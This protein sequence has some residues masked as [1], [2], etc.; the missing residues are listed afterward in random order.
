MKR[1]T[2]IAA[3]LLV[4]AAGCKSGDE[5]QKIADYTAATE[6]FMNDYNA[7]AQ[8]IQADSTLTDEARMEAL[9]KQYDETVSKF[10]EERIAIIKE[11][12]SGQLALTVLKDVWNNLEAEQQQ[13]V[14][15]YL[16][17]AAAQDSTVLE[18]RAVIEKKAAT[19]PGKMFTDFTVVQDPDDAE[20]ST[21]KF[22]DYVGK[23]KYV[24][25]DFWAS[26]CGPCKR[27]IPNIAA[28]YEKYKGDD[29]DVLSVAVW[30]DPQA[31]AEAAAEHGVVWNQIVN[32]QRIP[33]ELYGIEGIP[34]IMLVGP[35]GIIIK[36]DLRGEN[37]EKAV[38]E[39]LG[40]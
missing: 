20:A 27:E 24:L 3:A 36:R 16:K 10:V 22:S 12:P 7:A 26:W 19:A 30:D 35:D 31:T 39:A 17:G 18:Y 37:I 13:E 14:L 23:G 15:G 11:N 9:E 34:H 5:Q 29:F 1:F 40:R 21:V 33:T 32:A 6:Q 25:V 8:K 2:I 38:A 28:V 4:L